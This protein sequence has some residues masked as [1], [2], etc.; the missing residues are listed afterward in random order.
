[1]STGFRRRR[2][3]G[4]IVATFHPIEVEIVGEY[5][6]GLVTLLQAEGGGGSGPKKGSLGDLDPD[7]VLDERDAAD[8]AVLSELESIVD[9]SRNA[10][11]VIPP[12]DPVLQRLLPS[13]YPDDDEAAYEFRRFTQDRLVDLK[14]T[15]A[16]VLLST[17]ADAV[18]NSSAYDPPGGFG[19]AADTGD[20]G[21]GER[22]DPVAAQG[23]SDPEVVVV[24]DEGQAAAWLGALNDMRLALGTRLRVEQDDD[25]RWAKLPPESPE[26]MVH[27]VYTWFGWLQETLVHALHR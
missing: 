9:A 19:G 20:A 3:K 10:S 1:M 12:D 13:A 6:S 23:E 5:I 2:R 25:D 26:A 18:A 27:Q 15:T 16:R 24:L 17:L 7:T 14:L 11:P 4:G 21:D 8:L 22:S